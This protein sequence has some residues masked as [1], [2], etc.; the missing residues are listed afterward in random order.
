[1][2]NQKRVR[3]VT[4][5]RP[6]IYG[7]STVLLTEQERAEA[8]DHTHRWTVGVRSAAS[9]PYANPHP[10]QQIGGADDISYM[11][12]KVTFKL[13][14]TY[15]NALRTIESPPFEVT[16]TGWGEFDI[17]IKVFFAPESNEKPL[18]FNHHLKL[19][20]WPVDPILYAQPSATGEPT[21]LTEDGQP[22]L[23]AP[24][25]SPVHS[26]Q[27]EELVFTEPTE[28]FYATLLEHKPTPLPRTNRH[29]KLL[30]HPLSSGGNIGEFSVEMEEEEGRRI[31]KARDKTLEQIEEMRKQLVGFDQELAGLKREVDELQAAQAAGTPAPAASAS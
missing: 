27:Y 26:W 25:I 28:A 6:I 12:K 9:P 29:P 22:I 17:I 13:Y 7:N 24:V 16:E 31:D 8:G 20:P 5:A 14:E 18:T 11:I 15:K 30:T 1:M 19:H 23:P 3:G 4:V 2:S 10:N 21:S